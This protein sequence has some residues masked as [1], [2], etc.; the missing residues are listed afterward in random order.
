MWKWEAENPKGT[1]VIVH[2]AQEHHGRYTWLMDQWKSNGFNVIMGDLP[3]QGLSTRRRGHIDNFDEY[4]E[5]V[6]KWIKE[7]YLL[8]PPVF[9]IGH[10]MGG[11]AV[12]RT[13][14][15]K[16]PLLVDG[17]ILSS[18]CMKLLHQPKKGMDV[19]SKG[20]NFILPKAKFNTG[21]T[22]DM[23]TRNEEVRKSASGDEL[24]ITK[25]SVRWYREVVQSMNIAF[26]GIEKFPEVPVLMMQAGDD[27]I[28]DKFASETW[29]NSL[30][31]KEKSYKEWEGLYHE[32]FN[33]PE[34]DRVFRFAKAFVDL[35]IG[36]SD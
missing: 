20:L 7:A 11:L 18:P 3:G 16:S 9:V 34:R 25:V 12:I 13:L 4:I 8:K 33:E 30:S 26:T 5:E 15:E 36:G 19:L 10:S 29:F 31:V 22:V 28:V 6:E 21:L 32:I 17:V 23:A 1:I 24:Y 35:Q 2:G 14:Q 27:L